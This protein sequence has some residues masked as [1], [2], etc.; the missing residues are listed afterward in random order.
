[1]ATKNLDTTIILK[2]A[3]PINGVLTLDTT[4]FKAVSYDDTSVSTETKTIVTGSTPTQIIDKSVAKLTYVYIK[5]T[6]A[7]NYITLYNDDKEDWGRLLP[8]EWAF[9]PDAPSVGFEAAADTAAVIADIAL[10]TAP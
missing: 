9:F 1:M 3:D 6:D 2:A 7:S 4:V 5:N 8:G 10:F